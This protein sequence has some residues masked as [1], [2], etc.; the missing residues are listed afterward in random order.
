M[1][2]LTTRA[3]AGE[4]LALLVREGERAA[5]RLDGELGREVLPSRDSRL[6][7][8]TVSVPGGAGGCDAAFSNCPA[9]R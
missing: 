5:T 4:A 6:R 1:T 3:P 2:T 7:R 8:V 9:D